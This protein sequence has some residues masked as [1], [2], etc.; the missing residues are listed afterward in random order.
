M[1]DFEPNLYLVGFMGTGKT[2]IGRAVGQRLG[3]SVIDSDHEIERDAGRPV[4]ELFAQ[5]GEAAFRRME[6]TFIESGHAPS[7]HVVACGGGLIVPDGMLE[8]LQTKGVIICLHASV[9]TILKRTQGQRHRPLLNVEDLDARVRTLYAV[10]EP[11]YRRA[12][13]MILTDARPLSDIVTHV[14]RSYRREASDWLRLHR[15]PTAADNPRK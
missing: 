3:F 7:R 1:S 2:T 4:T 8:L 13:T 14:M 15:S 12:G 6:R 5:D 9:E 11:I 10:R